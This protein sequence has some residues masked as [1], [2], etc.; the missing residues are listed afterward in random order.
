MAYRKFS[1]DHIFSGE[2][3]L[4]PSTVLITDDGGKII[5]I[6]NADDAGEDIERLQGILC[7]GFIN[8][9]CHLELSHLKGVIAEKKGLAD[10]VSG[11]VTRRHFREDEILDSIEKAEREMKENGIVAAGDICNNDLTLSQKLKKK[12]HYYN[13]IEVSGWLPGIA[14]A[15]SQQAVNCYRRFADAGLQASVVPHAPYSVSEN[16]WQLIMPGFEKKVISIHNQ[17]NK[18]EDLF[19][20]EGRGALVEMYKKLNIDHSFYHPP[21]KRSVET[22]FQKMSG[23]ASVILVHNTFTTQ[24]DIDFIKQHRGQNSLVSF[25]LCPNANRYIENILPQV[26]LFI[27]NDCHVVLG[28]DSLASNHQLSILEEIKTIL[29][30]YPGI[31]TATLLQWATLNGAKALQMEHLGSFEKGSQPGVVL[32]QDTEGTT[33]TGSSTVKN[34]LPPLVC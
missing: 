26:D 16:L 25:C 6:V 32:I 17:E 8:A 13:F 27:Q 3:F 19:F 30:G 2:R 7:P 12:V 20:L 15:R 14:A 22:Y 1:A 28:T 18:E 24:Q 29:E 34:L 31:S 23:A 11:V 10:F 9:H 4:E 33:I 21:G 5:D